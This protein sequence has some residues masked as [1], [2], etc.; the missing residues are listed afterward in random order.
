MLYGKNAPTATIKRGQFT[1]PLDEATSAEVKLNFSVAETTVQ[2]ATD[3]ALLLDAD[4]TYVGDIHF[5][6]DGTTQKYVSLSQ[7]GGSFVQWLNPANWF[8]SD[9]LEWKLRL[10]PEISLALDIH[11]GV[12][13]SRLDL[14]RLNLTALSVNGG[15]GEMNITLPA[16]S[17]YETHLQIGV[18]ELNVT[19]PPGAAV[20]AAIKGGVG[21]CNLRLPADAAVR[22]RARTG[23]GDINLPKHFQRLSNGDDSLGISKS[24]I[25]ET[26]NFGSAANPIIIDYEGGV[27]EL[28]VR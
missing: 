24:G 16:Q 22:L 11:G 20:Q 1:A 19:V 27:G 17:N 28:N 26:S 8:H 21:E 12:G 7:S 13:E 4:L 2:S 5:V 3:P 23:I 18:G 15:V 10:S 6:N 9:K 14:S 25:W